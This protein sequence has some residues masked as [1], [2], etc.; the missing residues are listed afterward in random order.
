MFYTT[1]LNIVF[2][3]HG[4][5]YTA[6]CLNSSCRTEYKISDL[7]KRIFESKVPYCDTPIVKHTAMEAE[8][9]HEEVL[10]L[11]P[12]DPKLEEIRTKFFQKE[13][14]PCNAVIK[15]DIVFFGESL[16]S[17]SHIEIYNIYELFSSI[18]IVTWLWIKMM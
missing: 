1:L 4:H 6:H 3:C 10:K 15:P 12:G 8:A 7:K 18:S 9:Y 14:E 16:P 5:F 11:P 17:V 2:K 13:K